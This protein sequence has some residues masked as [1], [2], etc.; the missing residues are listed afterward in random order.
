MEAVS[1]GVKYRAS[2]ASPMRDK[3]VYE[4]DI[5]EEDRKSVV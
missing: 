1:T 5:I 4:V 3:R 2:W